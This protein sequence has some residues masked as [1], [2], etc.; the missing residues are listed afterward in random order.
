MMAQEKGLGEEDLERLLNPMTWRHFLKAKQFTVADVF[1]MMND[2]NT[3]TRQFGMLM[4]RYDVLL[5]PTCAVRVPNANGRYSLL[6]EEELDVW[7]NRLVDAARYTI[8]ANET[9]LPAI[10]IPAGL[11][12]DGLPIGVQFYGNF[13]GEDLLLRLAAQL[14]QVRP[15]WFGVRPG[16]HVAA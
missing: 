15:E 11:D 1:R 13:T 10:S 9:G 4:N 3:V 12:S 7:I 8:P 2:N 14:E 5:A 6:A 16:L